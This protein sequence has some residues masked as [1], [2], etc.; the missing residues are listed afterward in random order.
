VADGTTDVMLVTERT[1]AGVV[2]DPLGNRCLGI[3]HPGEPPRPVSV[4]RGTEPARID[5]AGWTACGGVLPAAAVAAAGGA[6]EVVCMG[7]GHGDGSATAVWG[8]MT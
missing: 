1:A 7:C 4:L 5:G 3:W 6:D 8:P 2:R